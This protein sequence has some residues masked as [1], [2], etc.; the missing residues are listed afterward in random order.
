MLTIGRLPGK[1][2]CFSH[3][4]EVVAHGGTTAIKFLWIRGSIPDIF[5]KITLYT[6]SNVDF[7]LNSFEIVMVIKR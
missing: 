6:G 1:M 4:W 2:W 3:L 5:I 7:V